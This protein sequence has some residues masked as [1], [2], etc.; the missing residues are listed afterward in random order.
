MTFDQYIDNPM[1]KANAVFAARH[2]YKVEY[3]QKFDALYMREAGKIDRMLY[4]DKAHDEYYAHIKIPSESLEKFYYDV[5]IKFYTKDNGIRTNSNLKLYDVQFFSNDPA[6]IY[7]Y[8]Y[9]F[10]KHDMLI[11]ELK[12]KCPR[13]S[14]TIRPSER[15]NRYTYIC[16]VYLFCLFINE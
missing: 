11:E 14:L 3:S 4:Y 8:L 2:T 5:V 9:V 6:F 1:G 10:R 7:T 13:A 12:S 15:N 16:K